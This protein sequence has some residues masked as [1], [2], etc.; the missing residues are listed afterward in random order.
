MGSVINHNLSAMNA[1]RQMG[2]NSSNTSKAIE[3]LSSG[4]RINRAGDDAAGLSIS[5]KMRGQIRGLNQ[6][7]KNSQDGVSLIQTAEGALTETH[8]IIQRMR[9][10]AVQA[11]NG[12]NQDEDRAQITKEFE[13]LQSE[14]TRIASDT[15]FNKQKLINGDLNDVAKTGITAAS[16]STAKG[17]AFD[18][19]VSVAQLKISISE[20][21]TLS[22]DAKNVSLSD[23]NDALSTKQ[24][25]LD[26][27]QA[28]YD[29]GGLPASSMGDVA[30][31]IGELQTSIAEFK[32]SITEY[33]VSIQQLGVSI[34]QMNDTIQTK[35]DNKKAVLDEVMDQDSGI[36]FQ[37][38]AN[39]DQT[40][41][42]AIGDMRA[43]ALG[44][45]K[46]TINVNDSASAKAAITRLDVAIT[47]VSDQRATLGAVQNRLEHTIAS[48]D[49][50]SEN[51]QAAESRIRDVDMANEMM[52]YTKNNILSQA[53]QSML[54]QANSAPNNVLQLLQG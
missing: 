8:S 48:T 43:E 42:L 33:K 19:D 21:T 11:S 10:L 54:A 51:L 9:E 1:Q 24:K 18:L 39:Q 17:S 26:T 52:N 4:L 13:Q 29:K 16:V 36:V 49:N 23:K 53:A 37:V 15:E 7:S 44:I 38:G 12:T 5:E 47:R 20:R 27:L 40:I 2:V 45:D 3:K 30:A 32:V 46:T 35:L 50:T 31:S 34:S 41:G 14:I 6:A 28:K 25:T 22:V